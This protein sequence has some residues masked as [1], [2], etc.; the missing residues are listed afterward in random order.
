M[1]HS[2]S[3]IVP[4]Q[5][6]RTR[7]KKEEEKGKS[8]APDTHE[9]K[10]HHKSGLPSL[11]RPK[12]VEHIPGGIFVDSVGVVVIQALDALLQFV[13]LGALLNADQEQVIVGV[14]GELV[15]GIYARQVIQYKIEDGSTHT[16]GLVRRCSRLNLLRSGFCHLCASH[17]SHNLGSENS[18]SQCVV[19]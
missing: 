9:Y 19:G 14:Q 7:R 2:C 12:C 3:Q 8:K 17:K 13:T 11:T 4:A 16:A 15:H 1:Q 10:P 5:G 18:H 6:P